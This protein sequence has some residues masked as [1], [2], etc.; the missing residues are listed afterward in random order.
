MSGE[1]PEGIGCGSGAGISR[2]ESPQKW[3]QRHKNS[4]S[5]V[6]QMP[7]SSVITKTRFGEPRG[8]GEGEHGDGGNPGAM[9]TSLSLACTPEQYLL[10][11][12]KSTEY[13]NAMHG[14]HVF[15]G[16]SPRGTHDY[17]RGLLYGTHP[18]KAE[19]IMPPAYGCKASPPDNH[20]QDVGWGESRESP[21][22][23]RR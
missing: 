13:M 4:M 11:Q 14:I 15:G 6:R 7:L 16:F 22:T 9:E 3:A 8:D 2:K 1:A 23:R 17:V 19:A 5:D 21:G 18:T 10:R 20:I 12:V